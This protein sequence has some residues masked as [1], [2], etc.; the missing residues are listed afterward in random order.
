MLGLVLWFSSSLSIAADNV[1]G[2]WRGTVVSTIKI[3]QFGT[4]DPVTGAAS[5]SQKLTSEQQAQ[6][7]ISI[8]QTE[9]SSVNVLPIHLPNK[10]RNAYD[11]QFLEINNGHTRQVDKSY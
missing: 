2:L 9:N 11:Y 6:I 10:H 8:R 4:I 5:A 1:N 3:G 7:Y